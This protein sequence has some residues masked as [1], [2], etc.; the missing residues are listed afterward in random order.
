MSDAKN[1]EAELR[2]LAP[3][4][5]RALGPSWRATMRHDHYAE[6]SG[7]EGQGVG[8][9]ASYPHAAKGRAVVRGILPTRTRRG[10]SLSSNG[11]ENP[12]V[13]VALSRGAEAIARDIARRVMPGYLVALAAMRE[14]IA[15][16]DGFRDATEAVASKLA[17]IC[18]A[19]YTTGGRFHLPN[20]FASYGDVRV[21]SADSVRI[22]GSFSA[23]QAE[24]M[25]RA[26]AAVERKSSRAGEHVEAYAA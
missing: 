4:I 19:E 6:L 15:S 9:F 10:D 2:R 24:A 25:L 8:I 7:P 23:E 21:N 5:A 12:E 13:T 22:E 18:G 26:L 16:E 3:A 17:G 11:I 20:A 14:R 1:T